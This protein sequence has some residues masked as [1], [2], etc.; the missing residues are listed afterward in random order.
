MG[1]D[2]EHI[3][4]PPNLGSGLFQLQECGYIEHEGPSGNWALV[5]RYHTFALAKEA[6]SNRPT[7][8]TCLRIHIEP[9]E[10]T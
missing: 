9:C 4:G 1:W 5:R 3:G 7:N 6:M 10:V 8:W 2:S